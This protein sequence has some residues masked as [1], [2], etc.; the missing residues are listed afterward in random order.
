MRGGKEIQIILL[1]RKEEEAILIQRVINILLND[2]YEETKIK[3]LK[4]L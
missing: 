2:D 1:N 3:C 4:Y